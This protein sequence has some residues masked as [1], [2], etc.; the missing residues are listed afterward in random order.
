LSKAPSAIGAAFDNSRVQVS[1]ACAI[2]G[3]KTINDG[4]TT[5]MAQPNLTMIPKP[6]RWLLTVVPR[7]IID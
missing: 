3:V 4:M 1:F 5:A 7:I 6:G 2:L